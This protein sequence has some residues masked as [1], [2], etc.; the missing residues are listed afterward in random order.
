MSAVVTTEANF[1]E[2]FVVVN[3]GDVGDTITVTD[4]VPAVAATVQ[5][6]A[7][8]DVMVVLDERTQQHPRS[9]RDSDWIVL[10]ESP[11]DFSSP[12][13]DAEA[14]TPLPRLPGVGTD[15]L[16]A[17]NAAAAGVAAAE[18]DG[19]RTSW[20]ERRGIIRLSD[21]DEEEELGMCSPMYSLLLR[22]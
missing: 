1:D 11:T 22:C 12:N 3:A 4:D 15:A 2:A 5:D 10:T 8:L 14:P 6:A 9:A 20:H 18:L 19:E 7:L 17:D 21:S 16:M 13:S